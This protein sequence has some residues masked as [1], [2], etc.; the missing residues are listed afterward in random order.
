L[1]ASVLELR[2]KLASHLPVS[3]FGDADTAW[4]SDAFEPCGNVDTVPED[5][6]VLDDNVTD[7]NTYAEFNA[8]VLRYR[9][10]ALYHAALDLNGAARSI[11]ST[12]E[13]NQNTIASSLND[14]TAMLGDFGF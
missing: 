12:C 8:L 13:L 11:H 10:I 5:V 9:C 6:A 7:M 14:A 2:V 3:V 1:F 4:L